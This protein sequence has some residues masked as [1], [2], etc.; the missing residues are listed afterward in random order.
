MS[1]KLLKKLSKKAEKSKSK[2]LEDE[3]Y[4]EWVEC[5]QTFRKILYE[6]EGE[7]SPFVEEFIKLTNDYDVFA[8]IK[9]RKIK[10]KEFEQ[11]ESIYKLK[12]A[13]CLNTYTMK[14]K[15]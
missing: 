12:K 4:Y 6:P 11:Y 13:G 1:V 7:N 15:I 2:T 3:I 14:K 10:R 8:D 9:D 5:F